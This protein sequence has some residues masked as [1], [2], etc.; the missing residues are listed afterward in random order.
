MLYGISGNITVS[1]YEHDSVLEG[2]T[3]AG[4]LTLV[5]VAAGLLF[6]YRSGRMVLAIL[7]SLAVGVSAIRK[8]GETVE[9]S[10]PLFRIHAR[11]EDSL[12]AVLPEFERAVQIS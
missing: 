4:V 10:E 1:M 7:W 9:R 3:T 2:M 5:L 11:S 6:Y 12:R 8:V